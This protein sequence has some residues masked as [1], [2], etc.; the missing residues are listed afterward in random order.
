MSN[1]TS[2]DEKIKPLTH[3][4]TLRCVSG[5]VLMGMA[6]LVPGISGGTMLLAA[7]IYPRF[8]KAVADFTA[9]RWRK[10]TLLTL[11]LVVGSA[12]VTIPLLAGTVKNLVVNHQWIMYSIFIGLTLGGVPVVWR[13][14]DRATAS[15]WT[16]AIAGFVVMVTVAALQSLGSGS[17]ASTNSVPLMFVAGVAGASAMILPGISGGYLLL[18]MGVYVPVLAAI[19]TVFKAVKAGTFSQAVTPA[20]TV[21]LPLGVGVVI[22]VVVIS[23]A[24]KWLLTR[25]ARPTLGVLLGLLIGAVVGLWPFQQP[26]RPTPGQVVK[27]QVMTEEKI[28]E[29]EKDEWPTHTFNPSIGQVAASAAMILAGFAVTTA[30][31][32]FGREREPAAKDS[33]AVS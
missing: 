13:M 24:L 15:V 5:G 23:N 22:G 30:I 9:L 16:G 4:A 20:L 18:V 27:G 25:F 11:A 6:N 29:L 26:V 1:S 31:A 32:R 21:I 8:V 28:A 33:S 12:A 17:T 7:G 3:G 14:I 19:D 2:H 10:S